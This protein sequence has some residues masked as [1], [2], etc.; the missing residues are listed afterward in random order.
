MTNKIDKSKLKIILSSCRSSHRLPWCVATSSASRGT[1]KWT[2]CCSNKCI[3]FLLCFFIGLARRH[4]AKLLGLARSQSLPKCS[5][6]CSKP[7]FRPCPT[8]KYHATRPSTR[9]KTGRGGDAAATP[10]W[11]TPSGAIA[12]TVPTWTP[13]IFSIFFRVQTDNA[14]QSPCSNGYIKNTFFK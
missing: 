2:R 6:R 12:A 9:G 13:P 11:S 8:A 14:V 1:P 3:T 5:D 4:G 10:A 7:P